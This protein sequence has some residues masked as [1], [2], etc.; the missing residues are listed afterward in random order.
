[1]SLRLPLY[2]KILAWFFLNL[3]AVVAVLLALFNAQFHF[4]LDWLLATGARAVL[5]AASAPPDIRAPPFSGRSPTYPADLGANSRI[6]AT[7]SGVLWGRG[8]TLKS[9]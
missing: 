2:G 1:M 6:A 4:N 8:R 3:V 7:W 5:S 9:L